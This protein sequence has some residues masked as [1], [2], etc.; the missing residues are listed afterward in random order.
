MEGWM[1]IVTTYEGAGV[2]REG[3]EAK[4]QSIELLSEARAKRISRLRIRAT[5][6]AIDEG[7]WK[8]SPHRCRTIPEMSA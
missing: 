8:R 6:L 1:V 2:R 7:W 5:S 4:L 3:L